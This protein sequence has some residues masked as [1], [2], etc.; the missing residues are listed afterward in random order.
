MATPRTEH[1]RHSPSSAHRWMACPGSPRLIA[2]APPETTSVYA[3]EGTAAHA[4]LNACLSQGGDAARWVGRTVE[5]VLVTDDMAEAVQTALDTVRPL[6]GEGD[7]VFLEH[8]FDLSGL[9]P[10]APLAGTADV[11]IYKP[12]TGRLIVIDY[13]HGKGVAVSAAGNPQLRVYALGAALAL[14][15]ACP[16]REVEAMIIQPRA[17]HVDGV[18][19]AEGIEPFELI[20]WSADLLDAM[21]RTL[22]PRAPLAAGD[23]C[24]FCPA[25]GLCPALASRALAVAEADFQDDTITRPPAPE[26]LTPEQIGGVLTQA[27]MLEKWLAAVRAHATGML[28]RGEPVPGWKLVAKRATRKWGAA[29]TEDQIANALVTLG[30]P[31]GDIYPPRIITPAQAEKLVG[32]PAYRTHIAPAVVMES[33][34]ATLAPAHDKRPAVAARAETDFA[35][36]PQ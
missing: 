14:G 2:Q 15:D 8:R 24:R 9:N 19:R 33:S 31:T 29:H 6:I 5:G 22:D 10:P 4:V 3:Q 34:G 1:V 32:K 11:V 18:I 20:E 7:R 30:V 36:I 12:D 35:A 17:D 27:D 21:R 26:T 25:A 23:H 16:T 13:K 28:E